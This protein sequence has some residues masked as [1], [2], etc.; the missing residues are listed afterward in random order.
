[1]NR[2][3]EE[4]RMK[5]LFRLSA[6]ILLLTGAAMA[7]DKPQAY[8]GAQIIPIKGQP[9]PNGV[10]VVQ[11]GKILAVGPSVDLAG[12]RAARRWP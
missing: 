1:M 9:I 8:V 5:L 6:L 4:Y 7:Q 3:L 11:H 10:L 12:S 2:Y